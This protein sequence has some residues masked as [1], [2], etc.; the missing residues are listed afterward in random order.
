MPRSRRTRL[1]H[2]PIP[3]EPPV[4]PLAIEESRATRDGHLP[5]HVM[6]EKTVLQIAIPGRRVR[7]TMAS[8]S[9]GNH[10]EQRER[11]QGVENTLEAPSGPERDWKAASQGVTGDASGKA[12]Q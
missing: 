6:Q 9:T 12:V 3:P 4:I 10:P 7:H 1:N 5:S 8:R 11:L 2:A